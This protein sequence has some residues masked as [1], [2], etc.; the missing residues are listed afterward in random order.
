MPKPFEI[1]LKKKHKQPKDFSYTDT[2]AA[3]E[4]QTYR[5]ANH[6]H[7]FDKRRDEFKE[8]GKK[9]RVTKGIVYEIRPYELTINKAS[10]QLTELQTLLSADKITE[11]EEKIAMFSSNKELQKLYYTDDP[12]FSNR[13]EE[14]LDEHIVLF[15]V[16]H[17]F[18]EE[19]HI[20]KDIIDV[21]VKLQVKGYSLTWYFW[22]ENAMDQYPQT[23]RDK[24]YNAAA[25]CHTQVDNGCDLYYRGSNSVHIKLM[26]HEETESNHNHNHYRLRDYQP[27]TPHEFNQHMQ[28]FKRSIIY[29]EF[30]ETDEIDEICGKFAEFYEAWIAKD[31]DTGRSLED[32]YYAD[33]SQRLNEG[34]YIELRAFGHQQEPCRI[35]VETLTFDFDKARK[36]IEEQLESGDDDKL[37]GKLQELY[38]EYQGLLSYRNKGGSR[39]LNSE[40]ASLRQVENSNNTV[41]PVVMKMDDS[42]GELPGIPN[43]SPSVKSALFVGK[44]KL[45]ENAFMRLNEEARMTQ[46][47]PQFLNL[48]TDSEDA[49]ELFAER[50]MRAHHPHG[51]AN[52]ESLLADEENESLLNVQSVDSLVSAL[53]DN[54]ASSTPK[55]GQYTGRFFGR[56]FS[57][58]DLEE[59]KRQ[60]PEGAIT[61]EKPLVIKPEKKNQC[62]SESVKSD[63]EV[64]KKL[65]K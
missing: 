41:V 7:K 15:R 28:A 23:F 5:D 52:D 19:A 64:R 39:G 17:G 29:R 24:L 11:F 36:A 65:F 22:A 25:L 16:N 61:V 58:S 46:V 54:D 60:S 40:I 62:D 6:N 30:F 55:I 33:V 50:Y 45:L 4:L 53:T 3:G 34:D 63:E 37:A 20:R 26:H 48:E 12:E 21:E 42:I 44:L 18:V 32:E 59:R 56:S 2:L 27:Y 35:N 57:E 47:S 31:A 10:E 9:F 43:W 1:M 51:D 13:V 14:S 38:K 49:T 8:Q